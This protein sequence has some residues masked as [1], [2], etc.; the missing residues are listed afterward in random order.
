MSLNPARVAQLHLQATT[1]SYSIQR[2]TDDSRE[3]WFFDI[4]VDLTSTIT[5]Y[6]SSY[7]REKKVGPKW[8]VVG[9]YD[10]TRQRDSTIQKPDVP[11]PSEVEAE[12]KQRMC[13][14]IS[15]TKVHI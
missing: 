4:S 1:E 15:N 8:K 10:R 6:L 5:L 13:R 2:I 11:L 7:I 12:F 3:S 9:K 14:N